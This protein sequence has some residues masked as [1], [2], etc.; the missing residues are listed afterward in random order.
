ME[1]KD[2]ILTNATE[3][4]NREGATATSM[5]QLAA[6][7]DMSDGNL[8]YHYRTKE[9]LVTAIFRQML[10]EMDVSINTAKVEG[11]SLLEEVRKQFR[12][13]FFTMYRYKFLFIE[14]NLLLKQ[15]TAFRKSFIELME[16]RKAFF[17]QFFGEYKASGFFNKQIPDARYE[18]IFEQ[19]F[20]ISDNW[21][22][23]VELERT[24]PES[25][26]K[27]ID[28]YINLCLVLLESLVTE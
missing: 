16:V 3:L 11:A 1:T 13:I 28:H 27:K 23:Y 22:K 14:S 8:R 5:R 4:F 6:H 18:I 24:T 20:I 17:L 10:Q 12:S 7:L 25:I 21:I 15:Y 19:I 26:D 9:D 2:Y